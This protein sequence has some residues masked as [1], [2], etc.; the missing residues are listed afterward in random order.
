MGRQGLTEG[1]GALAAAGL[2]VLLGVSSLGGESYLQ[3]VD[4]RAGSLRQNNQQ[5]WSRVPPTSRH[6]DSSFIEC[7]PCPPESD[8]VFLTTSPSIRKLAQVSWPHPPE[9][10]QKLELPSHSLQ[11]ENHNH[12]KEIKMK[13]SFF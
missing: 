8:P 5:G 3:S 10:R 6:W 12:R 4:S 11:N 13:R 1:A 7:L 2:G 9:S